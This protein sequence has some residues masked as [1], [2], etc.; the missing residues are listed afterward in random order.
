MLLKETGFLQECHQRFHL[1]KVIIAGD[2]IDLAPILTNL[3]DQFRSRSLSVGSYPLDDDDSA[4]QR[5]VKVTLESVEEKAVKEAHKKLA[6][7]LSD[8]IV[9]TEFDDV[10][11]SMDDHL[12]HP[13]HTIDCSSCQSLVDQIY[14]ECE[15][16]S[17]LGQCLKQALDVLGSAFKQYEPSQL[18]LSFNGG[19]DCTVLLHLYWAALQKWWKFKETPV[20]LYVEVEEPFTVMEEF[21]SVTSSRYD[22]SLIR[23]DC[24]SVKLGLADLAESHPNIKAIVM[25]TRRGD[26]RAESLNHFSM[27]DPGWPQYMRIC[28]ILEWQYSDVWLVLRHYGIPYCSL[29]DE[30]YTSVGSIHNTQPNPALKGNLP[31]QYRPAYMLSDGSLERAGRV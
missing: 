27:T 1:C 24:G 29:Y 25:G 17:H 21:V 20:L 19:K 5:Q 9:E 31:G 13:C 16:S 18:C 28:P 12:P 30:G 2:E 3:Q 6:N 23:K 7:E 22:C 11:T 14:K 8:Y 4:A 10:K 26:P 15:S